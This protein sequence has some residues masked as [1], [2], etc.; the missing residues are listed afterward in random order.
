ME[1]AQRELA[2]RGAVFGARVLRFE[3]LYRRDR[4]RVGTGEPV[5]SEVQRQLMLEA[6]VARAA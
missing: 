5:A 6:T 4:P 2:E 3:R 1:H